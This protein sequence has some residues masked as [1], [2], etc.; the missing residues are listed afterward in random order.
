MKLKII[1]ILQTILVLS[2]YCAVKFQP[3]PII[4]KMVVSGLFVISAFMLWKQ[5][6]TTYS[7]FA[8]F[9]MLFCFL[10]D[11]GTSGLIIGGLIA[12]MLF[13][14]IAHVLFIITYV[15]TIKEYSGKI[16]NSGFIKGIAIYYIY[17]IVMWFVGIRFSGLGLVFLTGA[18][19]YGLLVSTMA[20]LAWSL[21][22]VNRSFFP[23]AVGGALFLFS[24]SIIALTKTVAFPCSDLV[25]IIP[26]FL[27]LFGILY[28]NRINVV[29]AK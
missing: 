25:I 27:G 3:L 22:K 18:L 8:A 28:A 14:G 19:I 17:F 9:A 2:G 5:R 21:Y 15:K 7:K 20:A 13:F 12:S 24:D 6:R 23:A 10:G 4:I 11:L 1:L 16:I 29:T 26:Y